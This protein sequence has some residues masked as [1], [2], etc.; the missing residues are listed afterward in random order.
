MREAN[1]KV[2]SS[3]GGVKESP[4]SIPDYNGVKSPALVTAHGLSGKSRPL[5]RSEVGPSE[6]APPAI[7][8]N[9]KASYNQ[10]MRL[11]MKD[12][13]AKLKAEKARLDYQNIMDQ[14]EPGK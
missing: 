8:R 7:D 5:S 2:K 12:R 4:A 10:Y 6:V 3:D 13:R 11:Y 14:K 9:D 1:Y